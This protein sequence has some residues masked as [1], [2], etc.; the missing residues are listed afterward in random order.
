MVQ[1]ASQV[2]D[3][4]SARLERSEIVLFTQE[5]PLICVIPRASMPIVGT[6][7]HK[8]YLRI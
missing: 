4:T 3:P 5:E 6:A 7:S 2:H 1:L 8:A